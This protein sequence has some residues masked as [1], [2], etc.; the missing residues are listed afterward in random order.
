[1]KKNDIILIAALL[2]AALAA[3]AG[4]ALYS[5]G[6]SKGAEAVVYINGKEQG[7]YPLGEGRAV[8]IP[9]GDGGYNLLEIKDGQADI[10]KASCPDK[11]CVDQ[12]PVS[13]QGESLVCLPNKVVVEI[14]NGGEPEID[15]STN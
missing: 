13:R 6:T 10:T 12:R 15:G 11:I 4:I 3:L 9:A 7:R 1:M 2:A 8:K 5:A 14:E